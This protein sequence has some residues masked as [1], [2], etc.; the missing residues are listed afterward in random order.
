MN[1]IIAL[2]DF[3]KEKEIEIIERK[4]TGHPDTLSD[5][6]AE[7]LS[8]SFS[9]YSVEKFGAVLH[10]N[11]DKVGLL[12]GSSYV[13]FGKGYLTS[14]IRVLINGR[15]S[16]KFGNKKIPTRKLL[17]NWTKEFFRV[18]LPL[19]DPDKELDFHL[20]LST[21]S[22]PGKTYEKEARKNARQKWFEPDSLADLPELNKLRSND[23]SLGVGYAPSSLLEKVGIKIENALNS[24]E[25]KTDN[26]WIGND[27]KIMAIRNLDK[28]YFTICIPQ[29]ANYVNNLNEYIE[30]LSKSRK[31]INK[32]ITD[33]EI[34]NYELHINTRDNYELAELYLTAIGSSI[35]SGDEGLAGRGNR[36]NKLISPTKPMSMEGSCGKNPIYH[37]GKIY[38]VAAF[39]L[40]NKIYDKFRI[41]NE[42]Y[43]VSQSGRNLLDPWIVAVNVPLGF[44]LENELKQ[45]IKD[46]IKQIPEITKSILEGKIIIC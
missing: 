3:S 34:K 15:I 11:F 21:Q 36:V 46:E 37:V 40:A 10:H 33:N 5:K 39:D 1:I 17:V 9:K 8:L 42:V 23:T 43:L 14:P 24:N 32:I 35:E 41:E 20:N 16:S 13:A 27:I 29:V 31:F 6:L 4:G 45:I 12:G 2:K 44:R 25:Y 18:Y 7:H 19:I 30:N 28:F 26:R 22:S 38:Y